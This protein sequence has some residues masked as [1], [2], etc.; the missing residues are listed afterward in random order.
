MQNPQNPYGQPPQ[1]PGYGPPPA[2][3]YG[4]PPQQQQQQAFDPL[5]QVWNAPG[6]DPSGGGDYIND[7]GEHRIQTYG[8]YRRDDPQAPG[9]YSYIIEFRVLESTLPIPPGALRSFVTKSQKGAMAAANIK[10]FA[11]AYFGRTD[12]T[13]QQ[14]MSLC[15]APSHEAKTL[16]LRT[17]T[18]PNKNSAGVYTKHFFKVDD[19]TVIPKAAAPA[20]APAAMAPQPPAPPMPPQ[21]PVAAQPPGPPQAYQPQPPGPPQPPA[22]PTPPTPPGPPQGF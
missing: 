1:Q 17:H 11:F 13:H 8:V 19:G 2:A 5:A 16:L 3:Q 4:Q 10:D 20:P 7:S 12:V 15:N 18:R 22:Y 21:A 9:H 14:A 6:S